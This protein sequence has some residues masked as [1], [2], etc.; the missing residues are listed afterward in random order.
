[1]MQVYLTT[2]SNLDFGHGAALAVL[3]S[4]ASLTVS[5]LYLRVF[6]RAVP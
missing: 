1:M 2:F 5:V 3:L 6:R 4:V